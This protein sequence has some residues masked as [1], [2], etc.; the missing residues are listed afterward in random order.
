M[1]QRTRLGTVGATV[2]AATLGSVALAGPALAEKPAHAGPPEKVRSPLTDNAP[3]FLCD[4][5]RI[6]VTGGEFMD[7]FRE[8]PGGR[9]LGLT[10]G[11]GGVGVDQQGNE[12]KIRVSG[13]FMGS[14][15]DVKGILSTVLIGPRGEVYRVQFRFSSA[16]GE[17]ITGDCTVA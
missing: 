7:R 14:E 6:T 9:F 11:L 5:R 1:R 13:R 2:V 17:V 12:Y 10:L 3:T 15:M 8:L 16:E 4:G